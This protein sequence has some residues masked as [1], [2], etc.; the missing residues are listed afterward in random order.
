MDKI[1]AFIKKDGRGYWAS[2]PSLSG[3]YSQGK[4]KKTTLAN[5]TKAA[6]VHLAA[7]KDIERRLSRRVG[8][9]TGELRLGSRA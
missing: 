3:C 4:T 8:V 5:F 6:K 1:T 7:R 2:S 9:Q